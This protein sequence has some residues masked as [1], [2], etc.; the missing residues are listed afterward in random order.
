[1]TTNISKKYSLYFKNNCPW[2]YIDELDCPIIYQDIDINFIKKNRNYLKNIIAIASRYINPKDILENLDM[3]WNISEMCKNEK[4]TIS[5]VK[6]LIEK[7]YDN[8]I[9]WDSTTYHKL[10]DWDELSYNEAFTWKDII[11]NKDLSWNYRN[12][13]MSGIV[14]KDIIENNIGNFYDGC[15]NIFNNSL[16]FNVDSLFYNKNLDLDYIFNIYKKKFDKNIFKNMTKHIP[17]MDIKITIKDIL[18]YKQHIDEYIENQ[19]QFY[20]EISKNRGITWD[21]YINY[22]NINWNFEGLLLNPN[23]TM[24]NIEYLFKNKRI[25]NH[26]IF[27]QNT[28]D[29][30]RNEFIASYYRKYLAAFRIQN[31]YRNALVNPNCKLGINKIKRTMDELGLVSE[32]NFTLNN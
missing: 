24:N 20:F 7:G 30:E 19:N 2:Y 17:D 25:S 16:N 29:K 1:M 3:N 14:T 26:N 8:I 31:R 32:N 21:D 15:I 12:I 6:K 9:D 5:I 28:L 11:N 23:L 18:K 4:I 22:P 13:F 10:L 27:L